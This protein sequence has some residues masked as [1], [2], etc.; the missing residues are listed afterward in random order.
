ML[1]AEAELVAERENRQ[2]AMNAD[3]LFLAMA[4]GQGSKK[5]KSALYKRIEDLTR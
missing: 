2:A 3:L 4:A 5:A 1:F